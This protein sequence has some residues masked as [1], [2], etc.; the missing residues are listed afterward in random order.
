MPKTSRRAVLAEIMDHSRAQ[1]QMTWDQ[2]ALRAG[3][4]T[5]QLRRMKNGQQR[6]LTLDGILA[7]ERGLNW[8]DGTVNAILDGRITNVSEITLIQP[9][10]LDDVERDMWQIP[11]T[12]ELRWHYILDRRARL[13]SERK[14]RSS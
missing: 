13:E 5:A 7:V 3:I 6:A 1:Q 10:L 8:P 11:A 9:E 2:V 4:S 14:R 12:E